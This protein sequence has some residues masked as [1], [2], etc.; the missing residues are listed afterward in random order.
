RCQPR[1]S[2]PRGRSKSGG[3]AFRPICGCSWRTPAR[4]R[5]RARWSVTCAGSRRAIRRDG[6]SAPARS[7]PLQNSCGTR[8]SLATPGPRA[9]YPPERLARGETADVACSVDIDER[10]AVTQVVV[11]QSVAPDFDAAAVEAIRRFRFS[12][13]EIDGQPAAVRIRYVYHFVVEQ[14]R[15]EQPRGA[16]GT[17]KGTVVEAGTRRPI[18]GAEAVDDTGAQAVADAQG[19][20]SLETSPGPRRLTVSAPGFDNRQIDV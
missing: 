13:A 15:V 12:P 6:Q 11:E 8:W 14:E 18:A 5:I 20:Y 10:G 4:R 9:P 2:P 3:F 16:R 19:R 7:P 1:R 17:V